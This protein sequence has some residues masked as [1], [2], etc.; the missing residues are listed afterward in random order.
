[1]IVAF[2][3]RKAKIPINIEQEVKKYIRYIYN[4][5]KEVVSTNELKS[6]LTE[7]PS[8]LKYEVKV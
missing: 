6:L 2:T 5:N 7:I 4:K 8:A 3:C 1:M